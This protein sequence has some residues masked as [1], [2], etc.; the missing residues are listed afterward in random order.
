MATWLITT[1]GLIIG[2]AIVTVVGGAILMAI[3]KPF[4]E[5]IGYQLDRLPERLFFTAL[6]FFPEPERERRYN[7]WADDY[8]ELSDTYEKRTLLRITACTRFSL[9][10]IAHSKLISRT[11][12]ER[13]RA[14]TAW[15]RSFDRFETFARITDYVL[16]VGAV[17]VPILSLAAGQSLWYATV[18]A[19]GPFMMV[20][21]RRPVGNS[22]V[23]LLFGRKPHRRPNV[24]PRAAATPSPTAT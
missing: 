22:T 14:A 24:E 7:Q 1:V 2:F 3:K 23:P 15:Q 19:A 10:L 16:I 6:K 11:A 5:E 9:S 4:A 20:A 12:H 17:V 21:M 18:F 13:P 8:Q